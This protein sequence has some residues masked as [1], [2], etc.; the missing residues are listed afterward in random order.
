M[1]TIKIQVIS[2]PNNSLMTT[3]CY[4]VVGEIITLVIEL[5]ILFA[6]GLLS[7]VVILCAK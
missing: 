7:D 4:H 2:V 6:L 3:V 5:R 1:S